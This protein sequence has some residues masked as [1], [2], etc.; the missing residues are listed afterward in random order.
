[1]LFAGGGFGGG[2]GGGEGG[3][4]PAVQ[5]RP[6][7]LRESEVKAKLARFLAG[8]RALERQRAASAQPP[9]PPIMNQFIVW[10][11]DLLAGGGRG[12]GV[13]DAAGVEA[14]ARRYVGGAAGASGTASAWASA[15]VDDSDGDEDDCCICQEG[16]SDSKANDEY[17][18]PLET[19]CGHRFHV[20]CLARHLEASTS[21]GQEPVCPM[22][23]SSSLSVSFRPLTRPVG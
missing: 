15:S 21:S 7:T 11:G 3:G 22:C 10:A 4:A 16:L 19:G 23:R 17:G 20:V 6:A 12:E 18:E 13:Q 14:A 9:L 8:M 5:R 2:F 1:M